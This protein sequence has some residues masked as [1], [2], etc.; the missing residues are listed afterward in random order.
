MAHHERHDK[1]ISLAKG[2]A[3]LVGLALLAYGVLAL[4]FGD[5]N[6]TTDA[7][8]GT[9]FGDEFLGIAV[10]GWT[11]L[12]FIAAGA[13]LVF[14]APLHWGAK[15]M[16]LIV[17]LAL[18][19]ASVI[20]LWDGDDVFGI[21]AANGATSLAWGAAAAVLLLVAL[22]PRTRGRR[23][24]DERDHDRVIERDPEHRGGRFD[25]DAE[26]TGPAG[27]GAVSHRERL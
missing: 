10:N 25:R 27:E 8:D 13:L 12:L 6:F 17:G 9:V 7:P 24:T 23:R 4:I 3:M 20:S 1:G 22:L 19:A 16:A 15:T 11:S 14:G 18:G 21:F 2:P 5:S 26:R